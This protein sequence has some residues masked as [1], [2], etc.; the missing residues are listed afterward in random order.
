MGSQVELTTNVAKWSYV[1]TWLLRVLWQQVEWTY[2]YWC[3]LGLVEVR[4][5]VKAR[6]LVNQK[7]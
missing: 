4:V 5:R 1:M 7:F 6:E 2:G 3:V